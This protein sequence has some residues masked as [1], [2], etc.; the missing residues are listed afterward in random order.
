[1]ISNKKKESTL[2]SIF[3]FSIFLC[4]GKIY[5]AGI[6]GAV[7]GDMVAAKTLGGVLSGSTFARVRNDGTD[8]SMDKDT[9]PT[10]GY[11]FPQDADVVDCVFD[12][13]GYEDLVFELAHPYLL[14][15][16]QMAMTQILVIRRPD[17]TLQ[18][19]VC[20]VTFN[21]PAA[22]S[23]SVL[24]YPLAPINGGSTAVVLTL[25]AIVGS[26]YEA[27]AFIRRAPGGYHI[28]GP[29]MTGSFAPG[30]AWAPTAGTGISIGSAWPTPSFTNTSPLSGIT[31]AGGTTIIKTAAT[32]IL[33]GL[34]GGTEI[35]LVAN[36]DDVEIVNDSPLSGITSAGGTTLIKTAATGIL[37][38]LTAGTGITLAANADDVEV[39][40]DDPGSALNLIA[41]AGIT[42]T[43]TWPDITVS[44]T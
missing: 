19:Q 38:G 17:E 34:T 28:F 9:N 27:L 35:S 25:P 22:V 23:N 30:S 43:G 44:L 37:K 20:T 3:H 10:P 36:A 33:K 2:F 40:N 1:M 5:M 7:V 32:G 6:S 14:Q 18:D 29:Y 21:C 41:G 39:T 26:N 24:T 11:P 8:A 15:D 13:G 16:F 31:S 4:G 42:I 12:E